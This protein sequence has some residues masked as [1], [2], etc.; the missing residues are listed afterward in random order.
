[1][2]I[3]MIGLGQMGLPMAKSLLAHGYDVVG[4][5]RGDMS[6]F[7]AVGGVA[8]RS[9][10]DVAEQCEVILCCIP[11]ANALTDVISG[12]HGIASGDCNGRL[13]VELSTL[14][15]EDKR[16]LADV[17]ESRGGRMLDCAIS[18]IP[19]MVADRVAVFFISGDLDLYDRIRDVL[20]S[21]SSKVFFM[22]D[23]G[24]ALNTKMCANMLVAINMASAAETIA[25]GRKLGLEPLKLVEALK[26]GAGGSLQFSA[27]AARMA[28]G[29][30][31]TV[32]GSISLLARDIGLI[33]ARGESVGCSL[34]ILSAADQ[35]YRDA[36]ASGYG[37]RDGAAVYAAVAK[38]EGLEIPDQT[39]QGRS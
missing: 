38:R 37:S 1:M 29:D 19:K 21:L 20:A 15:T 10:R 6:E 22:G 5:R 12:E 7:V 24:A 39:A 18:G 3:G 26:D 35:I 4:Y 36:I 13:L 14:A 28:V 2:K 31:N 25:F 23:F 9:V 11:D 34:S 16:R 8:G 17:L 33:T 27:R 32:L 30:W